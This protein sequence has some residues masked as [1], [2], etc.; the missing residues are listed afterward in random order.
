MYTERLTS[1]HGE[2]NFLYYSTVFLDFL[3][4]Y[5]EA[6]E[7]SILIWEFHLQERILIGSFLTFQD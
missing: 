3:R 6:H 4:I 7:S 5:N 1:N 2:I